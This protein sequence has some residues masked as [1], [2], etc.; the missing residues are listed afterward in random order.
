MTSR[1]VPNEYRGTPYAP[2]GTANGYA[3]SGME[4]Y[5]RTPEPPRSFG[6][7]QPIARP[8]QFSRPATGYGNTYGAS[9]YGARSYSGPAAGYASRPS[10]A[11]NRPQEAYRSASPAQQFGPRSFAERPS[12]SFSNRG[13]EEARVKPEKSGAMHLFGGG[14]EPKAP[15]MDKHSGGG[16][17]AEKGHFGGHGGGHH[18]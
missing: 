11:F 18:R 8:Q 17:H 15:K 16:G 10:P 9:G 3:R 14:H 4:A 6:A 7:Q 13:F 1:P 2:N 5:N 12:S